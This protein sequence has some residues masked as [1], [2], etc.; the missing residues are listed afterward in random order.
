MAILKR[1]KIRLLSEHFKVIL[2]KKE[3][4]FSKSYKTEEQKIDY[5]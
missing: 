3:Q 4:G 1:C 2:I 5:L